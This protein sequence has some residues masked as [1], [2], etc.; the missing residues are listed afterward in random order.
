MLE[1][2]FSPGVLNGKFSFPTALE[3]N[4]TQICSAVRKSIKQV[5][6]GFFLRSIVG[7]PLRRLGQ[8]SEVR[9]SILKRLENPS[10]VQICAFS[11]ISDPEPKSIKIPGF[12]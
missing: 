2:Y 6:T 9:S 1:I 4:Q 10:I 5:C 7:A 3:I 12:P 8:G 11:R